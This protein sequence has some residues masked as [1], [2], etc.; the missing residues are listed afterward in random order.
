MKN[1]TLL[2]SITLTLILLL[3]LNSSVQANQDKLYSAKLHPYNLLLSRTETVKIIY[4]ENKEEIH[5]KV[6]VNWKNEQVTSEQVSVNKVAFNKEPLASCL[7]REKA[8]NILARTFD[9]L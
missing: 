5:C 1:T 4:S 9:Y 2:I 7:S 6:E 8:K 3:T